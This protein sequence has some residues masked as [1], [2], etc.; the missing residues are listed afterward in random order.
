[1]HQNEKSE[2][3]IE[4]LDLPQREKLQNFRAEFI[5]DHQFGWL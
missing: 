5:R 2:R 3:Y 4:Q 1:M